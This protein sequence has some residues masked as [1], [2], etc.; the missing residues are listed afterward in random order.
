MSN[1]SSIQVTDITVE[2]GA[3]V[4]PSDLS[5]SSQHQAMEYHHHQQTQ[6]MPN[7]VNNP[8]HI[9]TPSSNMHLLTPGT[10][11]TSVSAASQQQ[12]SIV[13]VSHEGNITP[14]MILPNS[15]IDLS[16]QGRHQQQHTSENNYIVSRSAESSRPTYVCCNERFDKD[17]LEVHFSTQHS[18]VVQTKLVD[19]KSDGQQLQQQQVLVSLF[20]FLCSYNIT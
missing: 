18:N 15:T 16:H 3:R 10:T 2:D 14:G 4:S 13:Y 19:S 7:I 12:Q 17:G 20:S 8:S 6:N 9:Y 11:N 1:S 5:M